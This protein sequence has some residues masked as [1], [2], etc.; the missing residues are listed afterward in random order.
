MDQRTNALA[1]CL[2]D[3][4]TVPG[5]VVAVFQA[6]SLDWICSILAIW[7]LGATYV[8][9]DSKTG[10]SRLG[11]MVQ[12]SEPVIIMADSAKMID[13]HGLNIAASTVLDVSTVPRTGRR[14]ASTRSLPEEVAVILFTSGTSGKPKGI[15]IT[16]SILRNQI[17][18]EVI[19]HKLGREV[20]LQQ[21]SFTFDLSLNQMFAALCNGG[22]FHAVDNS[23]R[24]DPQL[25]HAS[26]EFLGNTSWK[27][28]FSSSDCLTNSVIEV[29]NGLNLPRL[30]LY[31]A[32]G[33]AETIVSTEARID[34][35]ENRYGRSIIPLGKPVPNYSIYILDNDLRPVPIGF[36]GEIVIGGAG[37]SQGYLKNDTLTKEKFLPDPFTPER[38]RTEG[39]NRMY[40]SG[41]RG[42]IASDGTILFHGR[43][44]GD[45]QVKLHG[46]RV[47]LENIENTILSTAK[48]NLCA[49]VCCI[50]GKPEMRAA[51]A[52]FP[53][54]ATVAEHRQRSYLQ[55][56]K[57]RLSLPEYMKPTL[58]TSLKELPLT[59]H[60]KVDRAAIAALPVAHEVVTST[61]TLYPAE[62]TT[63]ETKLK[64]IWLDVLPIGIPESSLLPTVDFFHVGGN[65]VHL[66]TVQGLIKRR[67]GVG[68]SI[69]DLLTAS[70]LRTMASKIDHFICKDEI[71]YDIEAKLPGRE[72]FISAGT[73]IL[74]SE[75]MEI[76]VTGGTGHLGRYLLPLLVSS[77]RVSKI[78]CVGVRNLGKMT[79][80]SDNVIVHEG[81][82]SDSFL[83][84]SKT[85]FC[86]LASTVDAVIHLATQRSH[87]DTYRLLRQANVKPLKELVKLCQGRKIPLHFLSSGGIA[88]TIQNP[89]SSTTFKPP[90]GDLEGYL[91]SKWVGE[92]VLEAAS[93]DLDIPVY[94]Y[95]T[96]SSDP[97][98]PYLGPQRAQLPVQLFNDLIRHSIA[99]KL[100]PRPE[101]WGGTGG[102][103][104]I[105]NVALGVLYAVTNPASTISN[106][107]PQKYIGHAK[108]V[109]Y[110]HIPAT[111]IFDKNEQVQALRD[112]EAVLELGIDV[113][114]TIDIAQWLGFLKLNGLEWMVASQDAV[115]GGGILKIRR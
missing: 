33:P 28:A 26:I 12:E 22:T 68:I 9:L 59:S 98:D 96:T 62:L 16:H 74:K 20:V 45:T 47:E 89:S 97:Y 77:Q 102:L 64:T 27:L 35:K 2:A 55:E 52:V 100:L 83:G 40:R 86:A 108:K 49:V 104:P 63:T 42:S 80:G 48:G 57:C 69:P 7:R 71:D 24:A 34:Y 103:V 113:F 93:A 36:A 18:G 19:S 60:Q 65:S 92:R 30:E 23:H 37:V 4:G 73:N 46:V 43:I 21:T 75:N 50:Y 110:V 85:T 10:I 29:F 70:L 78:H 115:L 82:I 58:I 6:P 1:A 11:Q 25:S 67:F 38:W 106:A 109:T 8:P 87:W 39:W 51:H 79:I 90:L 31:N 5:S 53:R 14:R 101:G 56:L 61:G 88:D 107:I 32:Y 84:L 114:K 95:R 112:S 3:L 15:L 94:I 105:R 72:S 66:I 81:D 76:L 17:E 99:T 91:T 54:L 111:S 44:W 13:V 41:D